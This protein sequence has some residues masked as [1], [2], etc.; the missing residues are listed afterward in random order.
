MRRGRRRYLC[1]VIAAWVGFGSRPWL[2]SEVQV[3]VWGDVDLGWFTECSG[4]DAD[5]EHLALGVPA[6]VFDEDVLE[7]SHSLEDF[8][9]FNAVGGAAGLQAGHGRGFGDEVAAPYLGAGGFSPFGSGVVD[10]GVEAVGQPV[11]CPEVESDGL[12][13]VWPSV[14]RGALLTGTPSDVGAAWLTWLWTWSKARKDSLSKMLQTVGRCLAS[15]V[16]TVSGCGAL[17]VDKAGLLFRGFGEWWSSGAVLMDAWGTLWLGGRFPCCWVGFPP[18]FVGGWCS[19]Q[20]SSLSSSMSKSASAL[21]YI[22][23]VTGSSWD[24]LPRSAARLPS[25]ESEELTSLA[26]SSIRSAAEWLTESSGMRSSLEWAFRNRS[27]W[28]S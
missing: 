10:D 17:I 2:Y 15:Q 8:S 27:R 20:S 16:P 14:V 23:A 7:R 12:E 6:E 1:G 13:G 25:L 21:S 18:S 19:V 3:G 26:A 22:Q 11:G 4:A 24:Q 28:S 9:G 5:Y